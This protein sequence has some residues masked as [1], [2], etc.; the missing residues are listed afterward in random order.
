MYCEVNRDMRAIAKAEPDQRDRLIKAWA[1]FLY[2]CISG[3]MKCPCVAV[4]TVAWRGRPE[5]PQLMQ[6]SY[7]QGHEVIYCSFTSMT[8]NFEFAARMSRGTGV[9]LEFA[10]LTGYRLDE[11]S[12]FPTE[13]EVVLP[14]N[15]RFCVTSDV[16][17]RPVRL[18]TGQDGCYA[19][20]IISF[21]VN[22][23]PPPRWGPPEDIIVHVIKL[24]QLTNARTIS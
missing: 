7:A 8:T 11:V 15:V 9:V 16:E 12:R 23:P 24:Q 6:R 4:G 13:D 14:P 1:P 19:W 21:A 22:P 17:K 18:A 5:G 20:R 3:V 10:L 2:F